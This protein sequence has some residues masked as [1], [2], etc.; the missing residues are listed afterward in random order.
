MIIRHKKSLNKSNCAKSSDN[1]W[2]LSKMTFQV[3]TRIGFD[4][5]NLGK[6]IVRKRSKLFCIKILRNFVAKVVL[7]VRILRK[8]HNWIALKQ[9]FV[10]DF[11]NLEQSYKRFYLE[12]AKLIQQYFLKNGMFQSKFKSWMGNKTKFCFALMDESPVFR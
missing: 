7:P 10:E 2:Y 6:R 5:Y 12:K 3:E 1:C 11:V 8:Q 4:L 9:Y